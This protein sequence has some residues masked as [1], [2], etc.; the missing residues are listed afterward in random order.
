MLL[1]K[2]GT[3]ELKATALLFANARPPNALAKFIMKTTHRASNAAFAIKN[4]S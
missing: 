2:R 3:S 4:L 1:K